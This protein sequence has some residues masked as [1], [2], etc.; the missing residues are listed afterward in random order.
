V[1]LEAVDARAER[2]GRAVQEAE[3]VRDVGLGLG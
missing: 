1:H 2:V 3:D